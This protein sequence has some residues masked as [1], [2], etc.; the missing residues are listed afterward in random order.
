LLADLLGHRRIV[1]IP[2]Q[3]IVLHDLIAGQRPFTAALPERLLDAYLGLLAGRQL[4]IFLCRR[5]RNQVADRINRRRILPV[6]RQIL[7]RII[8]RADAPAR[9]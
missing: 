7:D 3:Q 8:H 6:Q 4:E 1:R 9:R 2:R 5:Q